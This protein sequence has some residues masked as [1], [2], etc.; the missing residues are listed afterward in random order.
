MMERTNDKANDKT[1]NKNTKLVMNAAMAY[2]L[3]FGD[4]DGS[5]DII[6]HDVSFLGAK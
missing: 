6:S 3:V 1:G 2:T 5:C 4:S